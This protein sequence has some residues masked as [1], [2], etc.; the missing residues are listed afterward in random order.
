MELGTPLTDAIPTGYANLNATAFPAAAA[1]FYT[2]NEQDTTSFIELGV[3]Y[4]WNGWKRVTNI[5]SVLPNGRGFRAKANAAMLS[6]GRTFSATG[7]PAVGNVDVTTTRTTVAPGGANGG[8]WNFLANPYACAIDFESA[9]LV[10]PAGMN[11]AFWVWDGQFDRYR[12]FVGASGTD[13]G[14]IALN[15]TGGASANLI[16]SGQ[17]FWVKVTSGAGGTFGFREAAKSTSDA[18]FYRTASTGFVK[19]A[20]RAPNGRTDEAALR[21]NPRTT[22]GFD[23]FAD[24]TKLAGSGANLS[25]LPLQG[26]DLSVHTQPIPAT[27]QRIP[28]KVAAKTV[29]SY[30]LTFTGL[31][32]GLPAGLHVALLD[33]T[34]NRTLPIAEG[35]VYTTTLTQTDIAHPDARFVLILQPNSVTSTHPTENLNLTLSPNPANETVQIQGMALNAHVFVRDVTG[36][37]IQTTQTSTLHVAT[38]P[39]GIYTVTVTQDGQ[40]QHQRLVVE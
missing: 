3:R 39:K 2:Y 27:E 38:W 17:G 31:V 19:M 15:V 4:N 32:D 40:T 33:R 7:T 37:I 28:L 14:S 16:A 34:Q 11:N 36:K 13:L 12:V 10:K 26:V 5:V 18:S 23:A 35:T 1:N 6:S 29:G 20:L 24:A 30:T 21:F 25:L 8:G 22:L 9:S